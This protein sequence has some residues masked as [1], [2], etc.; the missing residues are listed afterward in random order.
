M[1]DAE[2][3]VLFKDARERAIG[4]RRFVVGQGVDDGETADWRNERTVWIA[5]DDIQQIVEFESVESFQKAIESR[6]EP[7]AKAASAQR[8]PK[9][10]STTLTTR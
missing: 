7:G 6:K 5:V 1:S 2:D 10:A 3:L 4:D 9:S 8:V